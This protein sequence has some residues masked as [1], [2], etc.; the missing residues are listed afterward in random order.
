MSPFLIIL[1]VVLPADTLG[2]PNLPDRPDHAVSGSAFLMS[3]PYWTF[4][5]RQEAAVAELIRGNLPDHLRQLVPVPLPLGGDRVA[6]IWVTT[7]Y[8]AIGSEEDFVRMPLSLPSAREVASA[9]GM[10]LPSPEIVDAVYQAAEIKLRPQPMIP[11]PDM[12]S[13]AYYLEHNLIIDTQ[14]NGHVPDRLVAGHKKDLVVTDELIDRPDRVA[15][16]G[17]HR[18]VGRPI[19]P[20]Y[21]GHVDHYEDY[22]HGVRLVHPI[23][24]VSGKAV[25]LDRL[26]EN[27]D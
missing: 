11:G 18:A 4:A 19:Q 7:D 14:L 15:I 20:V 22:S 1:L 17:W 2:M 3:H 12:R 13:S 23:A 26:N 24:M 8:L 5:E 27:D 21:L 9:F 10:L 6:T 16:Y 25:P